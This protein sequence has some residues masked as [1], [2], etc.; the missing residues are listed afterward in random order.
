MGLM[1]KYT[2]QFRNGWRY[3]RRVP[4]KLQGALGKSEIT[5]A[6][7]SSQEEAA[8]NW[9]AVHKEVQV[10][11]LKARHSVLS[12][13][14]ISQPEQTMTPMEMYQNLS[15]LLKEYGFK[16]TL[17]DDEDIRQIR[18]IAADLEMDR[19]P[20]DPETDL[21]VG[22]PEYER[23]KINAIRNGLGE[24]PAPTLLDAKKLYIEERISDDAR[25]EDNISR[26]EKALLFL[27]EIKGENPE[28]KDVRRADAR[29]VVSAM[30]ASGTKSASTV[31]RQLRPV[32]AMFA[33][34]IREF[35]ISNYTNPFSSLSVKDD[36]RPK[37]KRNPMP[38]VLLKEMNDALGALKRRDLWMIWTI[39]A[40]TGCRLGEVSGL[41]KDDV[42]L[43]HEIPHL[44]IR[45]NEMRGVKTQSSWRKVP[46]RGAALD[47]A[48]A[49]LKLG[50][51]S[52]GLFIR[53]Y[54]PRGNDVASAAI[55]KHL[56]KLTSNPKITTHSL[57]HRMT[58]LLR[59]AHVSKQTEDA[60]LGHAGRDI[61]TI[62][63]G[64]EAAA[65]I[66]AAEAI[67]KALLQSI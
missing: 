45:P 30:L 48:K 67:D 43:D 57:R 55:L 9:P 7:G 23:R 64:G 49:A 61:A 39:V 8:L 28:I 24:R 31:G 15:L 54:K 63:Y 14:G 27:Q 11:F 66:L 47:A 38:D 25:K 59:L 42:V 46:L 52:A 58:D 26:L 2:Q 51:S 20:K 37:D 40:N 1:L 33:L 60:I 6:L 17:E 21:P 3:R 18:D 36:G 19:Y 56:R 34:A 53:Y 44:I 10:L 62:V 41:R 22:L 50:G 12:D 4:E 5:R 35:E 32:A 13:A 16:A 65:L 29:A